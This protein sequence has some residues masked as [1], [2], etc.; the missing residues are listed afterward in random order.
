M[1]KRNRNHSTSFKQKAVELSY[2]RGHA[3]Q[4]CEEPDIPC[5]VLHRW[6][7][8]SQ[9]YGKNSFPGR[10][11]PKLT[12]EQKETIL[13]GLLKLIY[14]LNK[15]GIITIQRMCFTCLHYQNTNGQHHCKLLQSELATTDIRV[16]CPEHEFVTV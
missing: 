5:S 15:A 2:A 11:I 12:D 7:R 4:V 13:T 9:D 3:K 16:D 10:G 6:R 1:E 14:E 8:E